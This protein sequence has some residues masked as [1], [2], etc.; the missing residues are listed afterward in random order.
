MDYM[1]EDYDGDVVDRAVDFLADMLSLMGFD[2][3]IH[4]E[5]IDNTAVFDIVGEDV[6]SI[7]PARD[8]E[9]VNALSWII[10]RARFALGSGYRFDIDVNSY[11]LKRVHL[12]EDVAQTLQ[13]KFE[14]G[15]EHFQC[16]GMDS[17]DRRA[18]HLLLNADESIK[19]MSNGYG[20]FRHL[21]IGKKESL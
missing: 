10:K 13:D 3:E 16:F 2:A 19:T 8:A 4:T 7:S 14:N 21:E 12:L 11:R 20:A 17:V 6:K 15:L 18:L 1:Y 9:V 5:V